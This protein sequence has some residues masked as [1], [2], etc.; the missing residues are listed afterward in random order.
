M[1][2]ETLELLHN[3]CNPCNHFIVHLW[4]PFVPNA[5]FVAIN[6]LQRPK[7]NGKADVSLC[8]GT[9]DPFGPF[10]EYQDK[11]IIT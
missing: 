10:R 6:G 3:I 8:L 9:E 2:S 4:P 1:T 7:P 5:H 11:F